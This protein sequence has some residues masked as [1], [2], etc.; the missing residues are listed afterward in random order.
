MCAYP[1][2]GKKYEENWRIVAESC[3]S[4]Y[5]T[6]WIWDAGAKVVRAK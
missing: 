2:L 5:D 4:N 6:D 1:L 3:E